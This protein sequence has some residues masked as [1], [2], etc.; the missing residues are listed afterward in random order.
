MTGFD[1]RLEDGPAQGWGYHVLIAPDET[2]V[3]IPHPTREGDWMRVLYEE[4][5]WP[6]GL[7]YHRQASPGVSDDGAVIVPYRLEDGAVIA[8][9]RLEGGA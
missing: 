4:P 9:Y 7:R 1:V 3:V 5:R 2:I 8:S 6:G